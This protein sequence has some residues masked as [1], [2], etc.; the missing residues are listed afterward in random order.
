MDSIFQNIN[1]LPPY[2]GLNNDV[3]A[4]E[5]LNMNIPDDSSDSE[6]GEF[7]NEDGHDIINEFNDLDVEDVSD[8]NNSNLGDEERDNLNEDTNINGFTK[9][10]EP[11]EK[12]NKR[13]YYYIDDNV[14]AILTNDTNY[15][16]KNKWS[17]LKVEWYIGHRFIDYEMLF[18]FFVVNYSDDLYMIIQIMKYMFDI[19]GEFNRYGDLFIDNII[20]NSNLPEYAKEYFINRIQL[21]QY[22]N[23]NICGFD[24]KIPHDVIYLIKTY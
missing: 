24:K 15:F 16:K 13:R 21:S 5:Y 2:N 11:I 6:N 10:Y 22:I 12:L 4:D 14:K 17:K 1:I 9:V 8:N 18:V 23:Y 20:N 19:F 3:I 7:D